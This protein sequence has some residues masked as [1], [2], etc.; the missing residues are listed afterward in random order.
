ME[1]ISKGN[2]IN[3]K[4]RLGTGD[5]FCSYSPVNQE[6]LWQGTFSKEEDINHAVT[7]AKEAFNIWSN[8][9][10]EKRI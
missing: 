8:L 2:F 4:W 5:K 1:I 9:D 6:L 10:I 3:G 7:A